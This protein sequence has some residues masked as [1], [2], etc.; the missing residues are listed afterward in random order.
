LTHNRDFSL[1]PAQAADF[2]T[3]R[4]LIHQVDINPMAL[5]WR[6][7]VLAVDRDGNMIGC[8][9]VKPH[10]DGTR[11]LA[12]IAVQPAWRRQGVASAIIQHLLDTH[13]GPL[14]LTCR[15]ELGSF[16]RKF[17]FDEVAKESLPDY[18]RRLM[19]FV[20]ILQTSRLV[21]GRLLV[22]RKTSP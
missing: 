4:Q 15:E 5:D 7:F 22:M 14:Y 20:E 8:G 10:R 17:G 6:R 11:E 9:Q 13:P 18:F 12:S 3:I 2:P 1:R 16:Y 21:P 19:R